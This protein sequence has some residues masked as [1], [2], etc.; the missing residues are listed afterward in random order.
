MKGGFNA[1]SF[2]LTATSDCCIYSAAS[3][4]IAVEPAYLSCKICAILGK[5][6][7][8]HQTQNCV[9]RVATVGRPSA[10]IALAFA[11]RYEVL[12][13]ALVLGRD[14]RLRVP[15]VLD[16]PSLLLEFVHHAATM[17]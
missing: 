9:A 17:L 15:V 12:A 5:L 10:V 13:D 7:R 1:S 4:Q 6:S 14:P 8:V 11:L 2:I 16:P 3:W